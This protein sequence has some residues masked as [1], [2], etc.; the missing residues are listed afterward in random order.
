[1]V[2]LIK[3]SVIVGFAVRNWARRCCCRPRRMILSSASYVSILGSLFSTLLHAHICDVLYKL[4]LVP[5][6]VS[7]YPS[8]DINGDIVSGV[9]KM[10]I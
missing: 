5:K 10:R 4:Q 1:M 8:Q 2:V 3:S 7:Q 6:I 9:A